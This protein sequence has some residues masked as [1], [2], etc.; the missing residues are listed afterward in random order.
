M[1][2]VALT[3]FHGSTWLADAVCGYGVIG[4]WFFHGGSVSVAPLAI[5]STLCVVLGFLFFVWARDVWKGSRL[6]CVGLGI[7]VA[8]IHTAIVAAMHATR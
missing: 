8:V 5:L 7:L 2:L 3:C 6:R 1:I 4:W